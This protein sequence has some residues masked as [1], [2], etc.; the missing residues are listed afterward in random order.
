MRPRLEGYQPTGSAAAAVDQPAPG[1]YNSSLA[2]GQQV[3]S[4]RA[5]SASFSFGTSER[6]RPEVQPKKTLY[7]GK[8]FERQNY[9]VDAP[10]SQSYPGFATLVTMPI[11]QLLRLPQVFIH[12]ARSCITRSKRL[13]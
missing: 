7:T 11:A 13:V 2:F 9:G 4:A 3:H 1:Q 8:G 5:T 10:P 6:Q 12:L